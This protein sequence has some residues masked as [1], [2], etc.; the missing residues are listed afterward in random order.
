M[1]VKELVE[2]ASPRAYRFMLRGPLTNDTVFSLCAK[3]YNK[4]K[5]TKERK[6]EKKG[7]FRPFF[8]GTP[9]RPFSF[10]QFNQERGL[11][12]VFVSQ[13]R[14]SVTGEKTYQ[15]D[16]NHVPFAG[17]PPEKERVEQKERKREKSEVNFKSD[18]VFK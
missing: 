11:H 8:F 13:E 3:T 12:F 15:Q 5:R 9:L 7:L 1:A 18:T 17:E 14:V 16:D 2:F 6:E 4:I 10:L